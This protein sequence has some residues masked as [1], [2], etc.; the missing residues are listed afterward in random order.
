RTQILTALVLTNFAGLATWPATKATGTPQPKGPRPQ[1][2]TPVVMGGNEAQ[3]SWRPVD[4]I[5]MS[6]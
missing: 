3:R 6:C 2:L 4:H 1:P 5:V